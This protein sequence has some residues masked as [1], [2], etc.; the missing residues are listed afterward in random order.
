MTN[1]AYEPSKNPRYNINSLLWRY[2]NYSKL[3][4]TIHTFMASTFQGEYC[5]C[6][7]FKICNKIHTKM[8]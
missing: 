5:Q 6:F 7:T 3:M 1:L 8:Y 2:A 4:T